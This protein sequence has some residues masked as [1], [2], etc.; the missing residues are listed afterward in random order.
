LASLAVWLVAGAQPATATRKQVALFTAWIQA[1][2]P[3]AS[4]A[5]AGRLARAFVR[6]GK[7]YHMDPYRLAACAVVESE[8]N[9]KAGKAM[10]VMQITPRLYREMKGWHKLNPH[11]IDDNVRMGAEY[12][13][14]MSYATYNGSG[15]GGSYARHCTTV[16][17][18]LYDSPSYWRNHLASRSLWERRQSHR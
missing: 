8:F 11:N 15:K 1:V 17:N 4:A 12:L 2:R 7:R 14:K 10:G 18:R 3:K 6:E 9:P 13:S 16:E 5:Y